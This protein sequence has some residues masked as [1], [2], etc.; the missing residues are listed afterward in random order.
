MSLLQCGTT[1]LMT[2]AGTGGGP[3]GKPARVRQ[4]AD[5]LSH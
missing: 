2:A 4:L 5:I 3:R 1:R